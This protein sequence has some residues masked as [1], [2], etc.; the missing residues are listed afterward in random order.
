MHKLIYQYENVF[1]FHKKIAIECER[2]KI[3]FKTHKKTAKSLLNCFP[4]KRK[5]MAVPNE[6]NDTLLNH[7]ISS[8]ETWKMGKFRDTNQNSSIIC[9]FHVMGWQS[10]WLTHSLKT[11]FRPKLFSAKVKHLFLFCFT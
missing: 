3:N 8:V 2:E 4:L 5:R 10:V 11:N 9:Q 6:S 7:R 1:F